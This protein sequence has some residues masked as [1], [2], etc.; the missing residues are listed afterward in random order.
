MQ[1]C[2]LVLQALQIASIVLH[3]VIHLCTCIYMSAYIYFCKCTNN[4]Y[5]GDFL[6]LCSINILYQN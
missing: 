4:L 6:K 3:V 2:Y 5:D 1:N